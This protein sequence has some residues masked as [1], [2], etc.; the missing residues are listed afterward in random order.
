MQITTANYIVDQ[1]IYDGSL[2]EL[3]GFIGSNFIK[4]MLKKQL[5]NL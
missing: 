3:A 2:T 1:I 4:M 5:F